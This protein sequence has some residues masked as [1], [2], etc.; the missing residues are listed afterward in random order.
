LWILPWLLD[1]WLPEYWVVV[2]LVVIYLVLLVC[3]GGG[4]TT[5][6]KEPRK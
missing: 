5:T 2:G 4:K 3:E 6:W 1:Y